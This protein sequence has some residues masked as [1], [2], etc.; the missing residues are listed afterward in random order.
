MATFALVENNVVQ[1]IVVVDDEKLLD[2][3]GLENEQLGKN[4]L[5]A[6]L[7]TDSWVQCYEDGKRG[8]YPLVGDIYSQEFD[9]FV[10]P[11]PAEW[12]E[13]AESGEWVSPPYLRPDSGEPWKHDELVYIGYFER[14]T[15]SYKLMGIVNKDPSLN[16]VY[17]DSCL[18]TDVVHV[19]IEKLEHGTDSAVEA[20][21]PT[22]VD[23]VI[24]FPYLV[25]LDTVVDAAPFFTIVYGF[26][27]RTDHTY[28]HDLTS[29]VFNSH[30]QSSGRTIQ[31][32]FRLIIEWAYAHTHFENN[33]HASIISHNAL[34]VLQMPLDVRNELLEFVP[35]QAVELFVRGEYPFTASEIMEN[36]PMP[37]L[38][39][40]WINSVYEQFPGR[41][42]TDPFNLNPSTIPETYPI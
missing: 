14:H 20:L 3:N 4:F 13:L 31:E 37:P 41:K 23:G 21:Q 26:V 15:R 10:S 8:K 7:D 18:T 32:L 6:L 1:N 2:D 42:E 12:Y 24:H 39:S 38:F 29:S 22:F 27:E 33:E 25:E 30:P 35:P 5:T 11:A 17:Y 9:I 34:R 16:F 40:N 28:D 36:P 19:P